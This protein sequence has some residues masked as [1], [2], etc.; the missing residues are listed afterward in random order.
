MSQATQQA[1]IHPKDA[2]TSIQQLKTFDHLQAMYNTQINY[3]VSYLHT[4]ERKE[5]N[6]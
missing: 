3:Q 4:Y 5:I 6:K 1:E 2:Q